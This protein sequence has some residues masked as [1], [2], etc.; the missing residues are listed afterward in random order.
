MKNLADIKMI[1]I[2]A[3][4]IHWYTKTFHEVPVILFLNSFEY[5]HVLRE[6][7]SEFIE[8]QKTPFS[9]LNYLTIDQAKIRVIVNPDM[10]NFRVMNR[11]YAQKKG[12]YYR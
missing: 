1:D 5:E 9:T 3:D 4:Y 2:I 11:K 6:L 8:A 12:Y 7:P 10:P